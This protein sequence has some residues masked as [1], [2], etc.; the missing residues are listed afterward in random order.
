MIIM[1]GGGDFLGPIVD[2]GA[3][4]MHSARHQHIQS[5]QLTHTPA[6]FQPV[7]FIHMVRI[8]TLNFRFQRS[9]DSTVFAHNACSKTTKTDDT[10][11]ERCKIESST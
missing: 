11:H 2:A 9:N 5:M 1:T 6:Q 3:L 10:K 8:G 7:D 4:V